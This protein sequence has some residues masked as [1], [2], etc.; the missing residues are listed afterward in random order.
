MSDKFTDLYCVFDV[1]AEKASPPF[2]ADND[3]VAVRQ[4][5]QLV[6]PLPPF[7][8]KDFKLFK[9]AQINESTM[10][11]F[12]VDDGPVEIDTVRRFEVEVNHE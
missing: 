6:E 10:E 7:A 12:F 5:R 1:L 3:D 9:V 4:F 2:F 8:R 11:I